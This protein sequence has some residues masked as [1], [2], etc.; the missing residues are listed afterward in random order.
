MKCILDSATL[1]EVAEETL[2]L[3]ILT[4]AMLNG[5]STQ[6]V[7]QFDHFERSYALF[8]LHEIKNG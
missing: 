5:R 4:F 1:F 6:M 8:I 7:V 2:R 3:V